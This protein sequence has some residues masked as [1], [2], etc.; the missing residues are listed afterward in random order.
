MRA[1]SRFLKSPPPLTPPHKGEGVVSV[2]EF[3]SPLWEGVRGGGFKR[4]AAKGAN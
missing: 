1:C 4:C 2:S 3:P